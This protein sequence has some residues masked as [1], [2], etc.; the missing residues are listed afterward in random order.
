MTYFPRKFRACAVAWAL[1][2]VG[3]SQDGVEQVVELPFEG[4]RLN[5]A[6]PQEIL[7]SAQCRTPQPGGTP[8]RR[9]TNYEYENSLLALGFSSDLVSK[10][11]ALLPSEPISLG[12]R[13]GASALTVSGLLAQKYRQIAEE[14][15]KETGAGCDLAVPDCVPQ[16]IS[17]MG[18]LLH[19]RP[20][21]E[22]ET[23]AYRALFDKSLQT[24]PAEAAARWVI[25]AMLQSP[26]FL[27]RVELPGQDIERVTGYEMATRL[28]Y[29]FWQGPPDDLLYD[30]AATGQLETEEQVFE[31][32]LRMMKDPRAFRIYEFFEQWLDLDQ[33]SH[34]DRDP[35]LYP[36]LDPQL[37]ELLR[38][39]SR[40]FIQDLL[41]DPSSTFGDL[42][43]AKYTFANAA[44]ADHY[45]L[46]PVEGDTFVRVDDASR[47]GILT[48]GMLAARD[49]ADHTSIVRRGLKVRTDFLCQLV[50]KPPDTVDLSLE[51]I[52]SDLSQAERLAIH[53]S[54]PGCDKCH[55]L[56][57]P[58]GLALDGVDAVGRIRAHDEHGNPLMTQGE[59]T[60][61]LDADGPVSSVADVALALAGSVEAEQCYMLQNFR[62]FFGRDA[63]SEDLCTQAQLLKI[64]GDNDRTL[65]SLLVGIARTDAFLYKAAI[66]SPQDV[67]AEEGAL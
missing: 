48:Q 58:I 5:G 67:S 7:G 36:D 11:G 33:L 55:A 13:N 3:C 61:T 25:I 19:R 32:A 49:A 39:E 41:S 30:A 26:H 62:F 18:L 42:L 63:G 21:S 1:C 47:S 23:S 6:P 16:F 31:Q 44:L 60:G 64:F 37:A 57:D 4:S 59:I 65:V 40:A 14:L 20:L 34:I 22:Q 15:A 53:R 46:P 27:Y 9:L 2:S 8:L 38:G 24:E 17:K 12:F 52:G 50:P 56:M 51:G 35:V 10:M 29:T 28:S 66:L 54:N 45:G 43:T